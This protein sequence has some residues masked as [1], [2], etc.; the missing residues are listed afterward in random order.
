ML[1]DVSPIRIKLIAVVILGNNVISLQI[2][3][4]GFDNQVKYLKIL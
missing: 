4:F 2:A 1:I 3:D